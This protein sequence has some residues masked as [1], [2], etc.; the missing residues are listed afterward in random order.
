M[1]SASPIPIISA[2]GY[3]SQTGQVAADNT[4]DLIAY[5]RAFIANV[6]PTLIVGFIADLF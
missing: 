6:S 1:I 2:G 5:G 3:T 4:G